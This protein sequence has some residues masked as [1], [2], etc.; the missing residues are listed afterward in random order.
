M[1]HNKVPLNSET[2]A[3]TQTHVKHIIALRS[4]LPARHDVHRQDAEA[5]CHIAL[6]NAELVDPEGGIPTM[7]GIEPHC[8]RHSWTKAD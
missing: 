6:I 4:D 5:V 7:L 2:P 8:V 3:Y 1:D